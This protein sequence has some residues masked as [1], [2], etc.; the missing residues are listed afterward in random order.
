MTDSYAKIIVFY[1]DIPSV[2]EAFLSLDGK[3]SYTKDGAKKIDG[4]MCPRLTISVDI[5]QKITDHKRLSG[6]VKMLS[7]LEENNQI[8]SFKIVERI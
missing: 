6:L 4:K 2:L 3:M 8:I 5:V 1:R 7:L